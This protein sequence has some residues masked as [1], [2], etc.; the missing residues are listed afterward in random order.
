MKKIFLVTLV[1]LFLAGCAKDAGM[2]HTKDETS[3]NSSDV[4]T[5][6]LSVGLV[7]SNSVGTRAD[8]NYN[9]YTDGNAS[10]NAVTMVRFFFFDDGGAPSPVWKN[11]SDGSYDSYIDW[12]PSA[13]DFGSGDKDET[14]AKIAS[15]TLGINTPLGESMPALVMAVVNP[16]QVVLALKNE[17][18]TFGTDMTTI[19]YGPSLQK[20][21]SIVSDFK[22]GLTG[23]VFRVVM[24]RFALARASARRAC[25]SIC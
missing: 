2:N 7:A 19:L 11:K 9:D 8:V 23:V 24:A 12:Y 21:R 10:E 25:W 17:K 3:A 6:Y 14:V 5:N 15:T 4:V 22:T 20:L 16:N 1:G 18:S 13:G